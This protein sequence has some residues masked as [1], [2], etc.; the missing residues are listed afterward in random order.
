VVQTVRARNAIMS[1]MRRT[2]AKRLWNGLHNSP[3][4]RWLVVHHRITR[5]EV[6]RLLEN[7]RGFL[8]IN[9][10]LLVQVIVLFNS[11]VSSL[12]RFLS[13]ISIDFHPSV[14]KYLRYSGLLFLPIQTGKASVPF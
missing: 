14:I 4:D 5:R 11:S 13:S 7:G 2:P 6:C 9:M 12:S 10:K 8:S 3:S 1:W